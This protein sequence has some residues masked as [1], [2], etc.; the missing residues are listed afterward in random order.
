M[1]YSIQHSILHSNTSKEF[2]NVEG[3]VSWDLRSG[4]HTDRM[5]NQEHR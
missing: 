1:L 2:H 4:L 5:H 3:A